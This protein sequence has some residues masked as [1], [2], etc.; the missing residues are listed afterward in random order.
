VKN[1]VPSK[2]EFRA[3]A[4]ELG[5]APNAEFADEM[6]DLINGSD[7]DEAFEAGLHEVIVNLLSKE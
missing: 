7:S 6:Y 5:V 1:G 2:E 4:L 3:A